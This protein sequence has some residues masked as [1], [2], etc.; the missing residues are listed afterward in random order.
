[1]S[2]KDKTVKLNMVPSATNLVQDVRALIE[3]ARKYVARTMN[4]GLTMLYWQIGRRIQKEDLKGQ[5]AEYGKRVIANVAHDLTLE[6]GS[7]F[8]SKNLHRS[9]QFY[10]SFPDEKIVVSLIRQLS[11]THFLRLIPIKDPL[12]R[13][14]YAEM[15]RIENWSVS[16]LRHK[17]GHMLYERTAVAKKPESVIKQEIRSLR[18]K[19]KMTP[20]LVF[21]DPYILDFLGLKGRFQ[22]KDVET[23]ILREMESFILEMGVGF[24]FVERQKRVSID[25]EDYYLDLLFYHRRLRR[26]VAIELKM[27]RFRAEYKGQMELYLRWLD[28]YEKQ[29]HEDSPIGLILCAGKSDEHVE[30]L[31]LGKSGIRVAEYMTELPPIKILENKLHQAIKLVRERH[32]ESLMPN[33]D[34]GAMRR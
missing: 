5:R 10:E 26:L 29:R 13:D 31:E 28:Q 23:A 25:N 30:L 22:E 32:I 11:W 14:F 12:K 6:Y 21:R 15:C 7:N 9:I 17:I 16:I 20:E 2:K 4:S 3:Q 33:Q 8:S 19:D 24:T 1:M 34:H 18:E 27:D